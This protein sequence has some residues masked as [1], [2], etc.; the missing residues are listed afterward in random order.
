MKGPIFGTKSTQRIVGVAEGKGGNTIL[1][2]A[3]RACGL[4]GENKT[5]A[6]LKPAEIF[7]GLG[8]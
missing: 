1:E 4:I 3:I 6:S 5:R 7:L 2:K 8:N